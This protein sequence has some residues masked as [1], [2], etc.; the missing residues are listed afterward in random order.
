MCYCA[1]TDPETELQL[2]PATVGPPS[3]PINTF[4]LFF[5]DKYVTAQAGKASES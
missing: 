1:V 2:L 3:Q 5:K 4:C